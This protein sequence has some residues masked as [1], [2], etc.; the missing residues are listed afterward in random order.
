M[1]TF[2]RIHDDLHLG[3]A[4]GDDEALLGYMRS[5][6]I[7]SVLTVDT[8]ALPDSVV[9]ACEAY[10]F[11][12]AEDV[13]T[14]DLLNCF[15]DCVG[16]IDRSREK[17]GVLVHCKFGASRSAA[18]VAAYLLHVHRGR[19]GEG[20]E[21][22]A[23][24]RILSGMVE[25]R[26]V[27]DP[28][29]GFRSQLK[30]FADMGC[31]IDPGNRCY[32]L[33]CIQAAGARL[34]AGVSVPKRTLQR[35]I[36]PDPASSPS[37]SPDAGVFRCA[38]CRR[39]LAHESDLQHHETGTAIPF[40]WTGPLVL[41]DGTGSNCQR[42][43]F[44]M[45]MEW[46]DIGILGEAPLVGRLACPKCHAKVGTYD[47]KSGVKCPCGVQVNPGITFSRKKVDLIYSNAAPPRT[48]LF[49]CS[50]ASTVKR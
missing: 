12:H 38:A 11:V 13:P 28:N 19:A 33:Y 39:Q 14:E 44:V 40:F 42:A 43:W 37:S 17:G 26:P 1:N 29:P 24:D 8:S 34:A 10:E 4:F 18:V 41:P 25:K 48:S 47:W 36:R 15:P 49:P 3:G 46:M 30:L 31:E 9:Q 16:F 5:R 50:D 23:V 21:A 2:D 27:V 20:G 45:P 7:R 22:P 32:R 6:G 35:L